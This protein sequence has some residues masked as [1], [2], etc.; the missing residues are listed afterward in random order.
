MIK[1]INLILELSW[2]NSELFSMTPF[3]SK[4][5]IKFLNLLKKN[6]NLGLTGNSNIMKTLLLSPN[7][8]LKNLS[9]TNLEIF[10]QTK[11]RSSQDHMPTTLEEIQL[12]LNSPHWMENII[13]NGN[14]NTKNL[15]I[16]TPRSIWVKS[17]TIQ[18]DSNTTSPLTVITSV[19]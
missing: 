17:I 16:R 7:Q 3:P 8:E 12:Q 19:N 4:N 11:S 5:S 14:T 15:A 13:W 2:L 1:P 18:E 10:R 9:M 6:S